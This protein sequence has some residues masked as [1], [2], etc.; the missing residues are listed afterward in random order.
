MKVFYESK[1]GWGILVPISEVKNGLVSEDTLLEPGFEKI[2]PVDA[3][4]Y[5]ELE[6]YESIDEPFWFYW[7]RQPG[8]FDTPYNDMDDLV[9]SL[10][11]D[12]EGTDIFEVKSV[13]QRLTKI[14]VVV[15]RLEGGE[16]SG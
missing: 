2:D 5:N 16:N 10:E 12:F 6:G 13:E 1:S 14:D 8:L 7:I 3:L 11:A 4:V 9:R 15:A